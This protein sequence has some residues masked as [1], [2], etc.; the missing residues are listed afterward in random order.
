M[1]R[2][3]TGG[4]RFTGAP[5]G[6]IAVDFTTI[7][8]TT[9]AVILAFARDP[10]NRDHE[11]MHCIDGDGSRVIDTFTGRKAAALTARMKLIAEEQSVRFWHNHPSQDSLSHHAW[12]LAATTNLIEVLALN[13]SGS[14]FVGRMLE[15]H[16]R[17]DELLHQFS[18]IAADLEVKMSNSA[19]AAGMPIDDQI[20]FSQRTGHVLNLAISRCRVV[21]YAYR[22]SAPDTANMQL[23][24]KLGVV[25]AGLD[26]AASEIDLILKLPTTPAV[27][28]AAG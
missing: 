9:F 5:N 13:E 11:L 25:T 21:E 28:P 22:L 10:A 27:C 14:I 16:D 8:D 7:E 3:N 24:E 17:F 26:F 20:A 6:H 15:W 18:A 12:R 2:N 19:K 4:R 23:A 1:D